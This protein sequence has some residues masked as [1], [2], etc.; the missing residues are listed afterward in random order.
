MISLQ[1]LK[2]RVA[3]RYDPDYIVDVLGITSWELV[4]A[5]EDKLLNRCDDFPEVEDYD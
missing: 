2:E 1:Q 4:E 5:F 3:D